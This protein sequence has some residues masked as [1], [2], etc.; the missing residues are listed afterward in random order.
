MLY[1][2]TFNPSIANNV[3]EAFKQIHKRKVYHGDVCEE[4]ILAR[5]DDS[6][7][8]VEFETSIIDAEDELLV[9]EM[10]EVGQIV[11]SWS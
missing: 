10:E 11:R 4:N 2:V 3:L 6:V 8:I 5:P 9:E 7:V 1:Q